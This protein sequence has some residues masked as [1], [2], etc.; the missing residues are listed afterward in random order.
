M[1][2]MKI[3]D[4]NCGFFA[5]HMCSTIVGQVLISNVTAQSFSTTNGCLGSVTS[6]LQ[7]FER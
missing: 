1:G 6:A 5:F 7:V 3:S 2:A 4:H